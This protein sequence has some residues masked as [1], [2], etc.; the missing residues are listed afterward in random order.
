MKKFKCLFR[1]SVKVGLAIMASYIASLAVAGAAFAEPWVDCAG[2]N[3]TC[4]IA[5]NPPTGATVRYGENGVYSYLY[6]VGTDSILCGPGLFGDPQPNVV[7]RCSYSFDA[8]PRGAPA[9]ALHSVFSDP[10]NEFHAEFLGHALSENE[11]I[12]SENGVFQLKMQTDGNLVLRKITGS[13]QGVK[14]SSGADPSS[15]ARNLHRFHVTHR[16]IEIRK[17]GVVRWSHYPST[18]QDKNYIFHVNDNGYVALDD[19]ESSITRWRVLPI[20]GFA[21]TTPNT[22]IDHQRRLKNWAKVGWDHVVDWTVSDAIKFGNEFNALS[23]FDIHEFLVGAESLG[24][25]DSASIIDVIEQLAFKEG[26]TNPVTAINNL[27]LSAQK[28]RDGWRLVKGLANLAEDLITGDANIKTLLAPAIDNVLTTDSDEERELVSYLEGSGN[29]ELSAAGD[30]HESVAKC[31][32]LC[33]WLSRD[34]NQDKRIDYAAE[35]APTLLNDAFLRGGADVSAGWLDQIQLRA[36]FTHPR[37]NGAGRFE[38]EIR[39]RVLDFSGVYI[40]ESIIQDFLGSLGVFAVHDFILP[41]TWSANPD[42]NETFWGNGKYEGLKYGAFSGALAD[43]EIEGSQ[44]VTQSLQAVFGNNT[45]F[46]RMRDT[47]SFDDDTLERLSD[48][49][50]LLKKFKKRWGN[51]VAIEIGVGGGMYASYDINEMAKLN[52]GNTPGRVVKHLA[53]VIGAEALGSLGVVAAMSL[54]GV[55]EAAIAAGV[56]TDGAVDPLAVGNLGAIIGGAL[57]DITFTRVWRKIHKNTGAIS[58]GGD[59]FTWGA[60]RILPFNREWTLDA[61]SIGLPTFIA[62][63]RFRVQINYD[64]HVKEWWADD[65]PPKTVGEYGVYQLATKHDGMCIEAQRN[66]NQDIA[67]TKQ[68]NCRENDVNQ[69]WQLNKTGSGDF[70]ELRNMKNGYCLSVNFNSYTVGNLV[71]GART[72]QT[73]CGIPEDPISTRWQVLSIGDDKIMLRSAYDDSHCLDLS[74]GGAGDQTPMHLWNCNYNNANQHFEPIAKIGIR[75]GLHHAIRTIDDKCVDNKANIFNPGS[76][77]ILEQQDCNTENRQDWVITSTDSGFY[78][79]K[80]KGTEKCI[81]VSGVSQGD[82][83]IHLW[84]CLDT[85]NQQWKPTLIGSAGDRVQLQAR[86]SN[87]CMELL[88]DGTY[89]GTL[90]QRAC[91]ADN[92]RQEFKIIHHL[93]EKDGGVDPN[94]RRGLALV[95]DDPVVKHNF[96]SSS[97]GPSTYSNESQF[98]SQRAYDGDKD[99]VWSTGLTTTN[100]G[101]GA[102]WQGDLGSSKDVHSVTIYNRTNCCTERLKDFYIL[103]SDQSMAGL[104]LAQARNIATTELRADGEVPSSAVENSRNYYLPEGTTGRYISIQFDKSDYLTLAEVEVFG[105]GNLSSK[106]ISG[107]TSNSVTHAWSTIN[108]TGATEPPVMIAQMQTYDGPDTASVKMNNLGSNSVQVKIEEETNND[109]ELNHTTE[110]VG[111]LGFKEGPIRDINGVIVG[112]AIK[113]DNVQESSS[114]AYRRSAVSRSYGVDDYLVIGAVNN[115]PSGQ[116]LGFLNANKFSA[117][118][119]AD[120][121]LR[122]W[123]DE[124][125]E[126]SYLT[127]A[128]T[129]SMIVFEKGVHELANGV[130]VWA[131][132]IP[133]LNQNWKSVTFPDAFSETPVVFSHE[134]DIGGGV[135]NFPPVITRMRS[136][137]TSGFQVRFQEAEGEDGIRDANPVSIIAIGKK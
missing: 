103:V 90:G 24:G 72:V 6:F 37:I 85:N 120:N 32:A 105:S 108:F 7:K 101:T 61:S 87:K 121:L 132:D 5:D 27:K 97:Q 8:K 113:L 59:A 112:D 29:R 104:S 45:G 12:L 99:G 119:T 114:Y 131:G 68:T 76:G 13:N 80:M 69:L 31:R 137:T 55:L 122:Y 16:G 40:E 78:E 58:V 73:A 102:Y 128:H 107:V 44:I 33:N 46:E 83:N 71:N 1:H 41:Y 91:D 50:S 126:S 14:W 124:W 65:I 100:S 66:V 92:H 53:A 20:P 75:S 28:A 93:F 56:A 26:I 51:T 95:D 130:V 79:I 57:G 135:T 115:A 86:H 74:G 110:V 89:N 15:T 117:L 2:G 106:A 82:V 116:A 3:Q 109:A 77:T 81:D 11:V 9:Q 98:G 84:T 123:Y 54:T 70:Y 52:G 134:G 111:Y 48:S 43:V 19:M 94:P 129:A 67:Q 133:N 60:L 38:T 47:F 18:S 49:Q 21:P 63:A 118:L 125:D 88:R 10:L 22:A 42:D 36:F 23:H 127:V 30:V 17:N 34:H 62:P 39:I 25:Y 35:F 64:F 96:V 4:N 136:I